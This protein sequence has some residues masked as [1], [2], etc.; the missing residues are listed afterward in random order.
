[1]NYPVDVYGWRRLC[2]FYLGFPA[3][4]AE[5]LNTILMATA[6]SCSTWAQWVDIEGNPFHRQRW[7]VGRVA[8]RLRIGL[9]TGAMLNYILNALFAKV[10]DLSRH[11]VY[12]SVG[13]KKHDDAC[14]LH[15]NVTLECLHTNCIQSVCEMIYVWKCLPDPLLKVIKA[16]SRPLPRCL[17]L[18]RSGTVWGLR[19]S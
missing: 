6:Q 7:T 19:G 3:W 1:M 2:V 17:K 4:M 10:D 18:P 15:F 13:S 9:L 16:G 14:L 12:A 8:G 5:A 11:S